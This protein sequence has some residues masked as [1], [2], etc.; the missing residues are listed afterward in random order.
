MMS[1]RRLLFFL[2]GH[3]RTHF[4]ILFDFALAGW[5]SEG[6][7]L[8]VRNYGEVE[9]LDEAVGACVLPTGRTSLDG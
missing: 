4:T 7:E 5:L 6:C 9:V 3:I 8:V 1:S 2:V